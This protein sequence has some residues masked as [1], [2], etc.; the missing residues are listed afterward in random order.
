MPRDSQLLAPWCQALLREARKPKLAKRPNEV[1][2]EEKG[3]EEEDG[4]REVASGWMAKKWIQVPR[5]LEQPEPE[6]LAKRRKGLPSMHSALALQSGT[7]AQQPT[8][9]AKVQKADAAGNT[10]VYE[11]LVPEGQAVEGEIVADVEPVKPAPNTVIEGVGVV[12]AEG[13]VV[14]NNLLQPTLQRRKPPPPKRKKGGPGR[15]KKKVMFTGSA[16]GMPPTTTATGATAAGTEGTP[17]EVDSTPKAEVKGED[18]EEGEIGSGEDEDD[19]DDEGDEDRE[20]GE[21]SDPDAPPPAITTTA[22]P[23][24]QAPTP[25]VPSKSP[26]PSAPAPPADTPSETATEPPTL[27]ADAT[28]HLQP[29]LAAVG[30]SP[31]SSPELPLAQDRSQ[32]QPPQAQDDIDLLD[33]LDAELGRDSH[34]GAP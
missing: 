27:H 31:S 3:E 32:P 7:V 2:E 13:L 33:E 24:I 26:P 25:D 23:T 9:K 14:A 29:P 10:T 8:R 18:E 1:L 5:H 4:E 30:R 20:E 15:G 34:A 6:Y 22:P 19:N 17:M 16:A 11:V 12:N 28:P 21:I